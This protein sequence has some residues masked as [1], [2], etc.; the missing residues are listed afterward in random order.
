MSGSL[1]VSGNPQHYKAIGE[2]GQPVYSVAFQLREAIRLKA[3]ASTANCLAIPQSNQHGSMV[4]WYSPIAGDV[5]PWSTASAQEREHALAR[6]DS[7]HRTLESAIEKMKL[8]QARDDQAERERNTVL[9][10]MSKVFY[11]PDNNFI[12]LV[13]GEPVIAF[14]G[15][16]SQGAGLPSDPFV[17]L[18][19]LPHAT[20]ANTNLSVAAASR[21]PWW[22][23]LLLLLLLLLLLFILLR[24]CAP[25]SWFGSGQTPV[26]SVPNATLP[27]ALPLAPN[28]IATPT[29]VSGQPSA[30][31]ETTPRTAP[32]GWI[33]RGVTSVR[34]WWSGSD[35]VAG[36]TVP[37]AGAMDAPSAN[38]PKVEA[39]SA[40]TPELN[41]PASGS[42]TAPNADTPNTTPANIETPVSELPGGTPTPTPNPTPPQT[43]S[44]AEPPQSVPQPGQSGN[45]ADA[46]GSQPPGQPMTIPQQAINSGD[47]RFLDGAWTAGTGIQDAK[48]GKPLRIEY[49][50]SQGKG[51]GKVTIRR[52]DGSQCVGAVSAQMQGQSLQINDQGVAKCSD[53]GTIALPKVTCIPQP[54]GQANCQ[55]RYENGAT[56]PVSMRHAP[57]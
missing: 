7:A 28:Q 49:D 40:A 43:P 27:S 57:K 48:T 18:R 31:L 5:V 46:A 15:F 37:G 17:S 3:G 30:T 47:T 19:P 11:F 1:L 42:E 10:L 14:W 33:G 41:L 34:R 29:G 6:L 16:H 38:A 51:Q 21:R 9:P 8:A 26:I 35:P 55:G 2:G 50:F 54:N 45:R 44:Q 36:T 12:Y 4:D 52:A 13:N 22:W 24:S 56:F 53:G 20:V 25:V 23:W 32:D 39:P